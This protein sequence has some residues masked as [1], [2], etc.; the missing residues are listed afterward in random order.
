MQQGYS[1]GMSY[2]EVVC[3]MLQQPDRLGCW[4]YGLGGC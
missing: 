1:H 2:T 3:L 4:P